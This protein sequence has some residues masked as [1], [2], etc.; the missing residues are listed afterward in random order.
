[1]RAWDGNKAIFIKEE[2]VLDEIEE[3][4]AAMKL[5]PEMLAEV[6]SY[7]KM[8]SEAEQDFHKRKIA[9]LHSEHT[10]I[11][12]RMDKLTDLFLD[13]D[14]AKETHEDKRAQLIANREK[15]TLEIESYSKADDNFSKAMIS[16]VELAS[17]ALH[18]FKGSTTEDKRKLINLVFAN[19]KLT[20]QKLDFALRP[21]FDVFVKSLKTR[22]WWAVEDSNFRPL[23]CQRNALTN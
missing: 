13:G 16:L 5:E 11:M 3:V 20:G 22:E 1:M 23:R 10:K 17:R 15:I 21:P 8:S 18:T 9:E 2:K 4:F 14:I 6:I 19:L 12:T 7:I